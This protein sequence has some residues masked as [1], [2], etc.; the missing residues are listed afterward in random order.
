MWTVLGR[1][2]CRVL[3]H[4]LRAHDERGNAGA[5][6]VATR[7]PVPRS[8]ADL[9]VAAAFLFALAFGAG[10]T[11]GAVEVVEPQG[12]WRRAVLIVGGILSYQGAWAWA[13][14]ISR[15]MRS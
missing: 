10:L 12:D 1:A 9:T 13:R 15:R 3:L 5:R 7:P 8:G 4:H 2:P 11:W 6:V 14:F